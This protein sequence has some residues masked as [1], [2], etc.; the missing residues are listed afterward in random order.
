LAFRA[1]EKNPPA[2]FNNVAY[3]LHSPVQQWH[4]LLKIN[5]MNVIAATK[6]VGAH[7]WVPTT[8]GVS[9]VNASF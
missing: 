7:F 3:S 4:G 9:E 8:C 5:D 1:D 2:T 6:Q